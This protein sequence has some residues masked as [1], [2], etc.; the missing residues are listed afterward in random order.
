MFYSLTFKIK[1]MEKPPIGLRPKFVV[2]LDRLQEIKEAIVRYMN[3]NEQI[4]V[5]WIEEYNQTLKKIK[6]RD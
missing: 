2:Y 6:D 1:I 4:K 5:E 3:A